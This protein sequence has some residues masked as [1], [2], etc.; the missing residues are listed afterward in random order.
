LIVDAMAGMRQEDADLLMQ[1]RQAGVPVV[2]AL[3][4][5][6]LVSKDLKRVVSDIENKL[7]IPVVPISAKT[8]AGVAD[9]LM[10]AIIQ[11]HP[12]MA[13]T[14]GRALPRYRRTA[15]RKVIQDSAWIA[16]LVGGEPIPLVGLPFLVGVQIGMLLRLATI[17]GEEM[18]AA[19]ARELLTAIA[20][21]AAIRYAAQELVKLIPGPGWLIAGAAAWTGT[22]ALGGAAIA[23]FESSQKLTGVELRDL[24]KKLRWKRQLPHAP[25]DGTD[26][27]A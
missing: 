20:G 3:N 22:A 4:K 13:V 7:G 5:I 14:I 2:V 23:F 10:P 26:G 16:S 18:G 1:V 11:A 24:Y 12:R 6:D 19:R 21:G 27:H 15:S 17:Y 25:L 9:K 8:G